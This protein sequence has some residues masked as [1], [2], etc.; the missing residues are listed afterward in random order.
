MTVIE[1]GSRLT[2]VRTVQQQDQHRAEVRAE[3]A[4]AAAR[5]NAA[6]QKAKR[7]QR[8][9]GWADR[10]AIAAIY[11]EAER[12]TRRTGVQW[13]VDHI[14]PLQGELVSGLH[15]ETNLRVVRR[16]ENRLKWNRFVVGGEGFEPPTPSV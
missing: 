4:R 15:V 3:R 11:L 10:K 9:V 7:L 14:I 6:Q 12:R 5:E 2:V 16:E 8:F 13:E 1:L